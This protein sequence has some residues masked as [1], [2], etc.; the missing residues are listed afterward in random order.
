MNSDIVEAMLSVAGG[1]L[2]KFAAWAVCPGGGNHVSVLSAHPQDIQG[3][4]EKA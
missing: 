2:G 4:I 1:H 3:N